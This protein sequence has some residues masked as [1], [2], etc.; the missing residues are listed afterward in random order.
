MN[1]DRTTNAFS[2]IVEKCR[3]RATSGLMVKVRSECSACSR[4]RPRLPG[5][6]PPAGACP[7]LDAMPS[8]EPSAFY[9][10]GAWRTISDPPFLKRSHT[11]YDE[12]I[13]QQD[14]RQSGVVRHETDHS[15]KRQLPNRDAG[16]GA[17][18]QLSQGMKESSAFLRETE[19]DWEAILRRI[20]GRE[21]DG[22]QESQASSTSTAAISTSQSQ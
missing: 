7:D 2:L 13:R 16:A 10:R 18:R 12:K 1:S 5:S 21:G 6:L 11:D 22:S 3:R 4:L 17:K 14:N 9:I 20:S 19:D 15:A 8:G